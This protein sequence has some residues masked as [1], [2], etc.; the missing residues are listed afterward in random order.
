MSSSLGALAPVGDVLADAAAEEPGVLQHHAEQAAQVAARDVARVHA[1]H[2]DAARVDLVEAQQQVH[3]RR[4]A[5][6]GGPDDGHG[7]AL[8]HVQGEVLDERRV[9]QV[10]EGDV[11]QRD[12]AAG[13]LEHDALGGVGLFFALVEE[14]EDALGRRRRA[15]QHVHDAG[16]L[17]DGHGELAGVLDEGLSRRR[18]RCARWPP[19]GRRPR[20][21]PRS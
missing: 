7:L 16:H 6:A 18:A 13:V 5:G 14:L 4:L 9:R 19:S 21:W 2:E 17:G 1:V 11:L 12:V 20:R 8:P 15:L 10:A 3:E